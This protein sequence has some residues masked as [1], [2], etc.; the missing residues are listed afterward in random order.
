MISFCSLRGAAPSTCTCCAVQQNGAVPGGRAEIRQS[1]KKTPKFTSSLL[2][3]WTT[4]DRLDEEAQLSL[5]YLDN[6]YGLYSYGLYSYNLINRPCLDDVC[7]CVNART[8][9]PALWVAQPPLP[10]SHARVRARARTHSDHAAYAYAYTRL[11]DG[12]QDRRERECVCVCVRVRVCV[13]AY[14]RE[15]AMYMYVPA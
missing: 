9:T 7:T 11:H 5:P 15:Y 4:T 8:H 3:Y 6:S 1:T 14:A 12:Q 13:C 2:S 10:P